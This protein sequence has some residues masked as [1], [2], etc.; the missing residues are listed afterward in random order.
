M[1]TYRCLDALCAVGIEKGDIID[2]ASVN[3]EMGFEKY[4][5]Y[6]FKMK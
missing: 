4:L 3:G 1:E 2:I 6:K 5:N